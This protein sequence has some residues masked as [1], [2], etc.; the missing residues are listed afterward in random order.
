MSKV[1]ERCNTS[2]NTFKN[3]S[4]TT[5]DTLEVTS[6]L[7]LSESHEKQYRTAIRKKF[8]QET[9]RRLIDVAD[10]KQQKQYWKSWHCNSVLLQ[11][12]TVLQGSLC[13]KRWCQHCN[14]IKTAEL[15]KGYHAP[16]VDMQKDDSL[17]FVTLTAPTVSGRKLSSEID[18]RNKAF[19]RIKDNLRKNYTI[20]L[21][22]IRK[23][24]I[25][26]TK[27]GKFHPHF[28][29][30][31]QGKEAAVRLQDLWLDQFPNANL[32]AQDI[33]L[34]DSSDANNLLEV[35]KYAVKPEVKD[36]THAK[37]YNHIY[38]C[39]ERRRT[40]QTF[41]TIRKVKEPKEAKT[42]RI[43]CDWIEPRFEIW[44][45]DS[46]KA[47]YTTAYDETL[48]GTEYINAHVK[49]TVNNSPL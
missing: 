23:L 21:N 41:G 38:K 1:K 13:R 46:D 18:K 10:T 47:D 29:L 33:T 44:H 19:S 39:L 3:N 8:N 2:N 7:F 28:H 42:E 11:N 36:L 24:E 27:D 34:I 14:R 22:G 15:I 4:S 25:T 45:F 5:L 12:E 32:K 16:L 30:I 43:N 9:F 17:Y 6:D 48:I 49:E 40:I 26:Y 31:I 37:A 35:F 20:K